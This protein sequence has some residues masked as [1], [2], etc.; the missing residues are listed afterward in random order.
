MYY[1]RHEVLKLN[2]HLWSY[3]I[4]LSVSN[5][6][7]MCV[8]DPSSTSTYCTNSEYFFH[9]KSLIHFIDD[10]LNVITWSP[11]LLYPNPS[12]PSP[13]ESTFFT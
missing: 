8:S 12:P 9:V 1:F 3:L 6:L 7:V 4:K 10:N 5:T 13:F 2:Y 11:P